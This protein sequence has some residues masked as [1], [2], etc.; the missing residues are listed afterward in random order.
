MSMPHTIASVT[1]LRNSRKY[2]HLSLPYVNFLN[3]FV[4]VCFD[5][6]I[7]VFELSLM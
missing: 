5:N 7:V 3:Y 4:S 1:S 2:K 6:V